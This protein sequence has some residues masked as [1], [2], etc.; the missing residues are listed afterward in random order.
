M[1]QFHFDPDTYA[2]LMAAEVPA[3][4]RLQDAVRDATIGVARTG[5]VLDLGTGTG[6]TARGVL[7]AH[8]GATLVG[9]DESAAMLDHARAAL[10]VDTEL[11]VG[12]LQD[13]LPAG[14]F[15]LVVSALAVHHLDGPE[16]AD[17]FTRVAWQLVPGG[18][19]VLG[20]LVI[21]EDPADA[22]TPIDDA[23]DTPSTAADQIRWLS[24]AGFA[25]EIAWEDRDLAVFVADRDR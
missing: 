23:Y 18:R 11:R 22:V 16:K 9:V 7:Q 21:P 2:E 14:P 4:A 13:P 12:R 3:Y 5:R 15:D 19:F 20:D 10:P 8:P 1:A 17:L 6:V 24:E 25:V